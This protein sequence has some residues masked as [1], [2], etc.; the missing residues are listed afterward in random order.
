M[1][2]LH[3]KKAVLMKKSV[4]LFVFKFFNENFLQMLKMEAKVDISHR[5]MPLLYGKF[6]QIPTVQICLLI[7]KKLNES[8]IIFFIETYVGHAIHARCICSYLSTFRY[9][10]ANLSD[11]C[12]VINESSR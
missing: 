12:F 6:W 9:I 4:K 8:R 1:R 7:W 5:G 10:L 11:R 2:Q 3:E